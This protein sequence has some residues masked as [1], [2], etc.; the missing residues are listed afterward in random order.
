MSPNL[1]TSTR[2][3]QNF[4]IVPVQIQLLGKFEAKVNG[5]PLD[6][7]GKVVAFLAIRCGEIVERREIIEA[8]YPEADLTTALNRLRVALTKLRKHL[9]SALRES[10]QELYLDAEFVQTDLRHVQELI[11]SYRDHVTPEDEIQALKEILP[12]VEAEFLTGWNDAWVET[13]RSRWKRALSEPLQ[14]LVQL[15]WDARLVELT[16]DAARAALQLDSVQEGLWLTY[17]R[18]AA[19]QGKGPEAVAEWRRL[20]S[21]AHR[22]TL[23]AARDLARSL[24]LG[25]EATGREDLSLTPAERNFA[26]QVLERIL[27][28]NPTLAQEVL[29]APEILPLVG[30]HPRMTL[31]LLDR[32][33]ATEGTKEEVWVR[34]LARGIGLKAWLNDAQGVLEAAPK[35]LERTEEPL[36]KRAVWNAVSSAKAVQR[37]W[38]GAMEAIDRAIEIACAMPDPI[39]RISGIGNR[40]S[41]LWLQGHFETAL[42][43]YDAILADLSQMNSERAALEATVAKGNRAYIPTMQGDFATGLAW[44]EEA[45]RER[46]TNG[47]RIPLGLMGPCLA[48]LRLWASEP[49]GALDLMRDGLLE[50]FA[51]ESS[52][53]QQ[54]SIEYAGGGLIA[55]GEQNLARQILDWADDWRRQTGHLRAPAEEMLV[56]RLIEGVRAPDKPL[57]NLAPK[58]VAH[59]ALQRLRSALSSQKY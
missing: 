22:E 51:S 46:I 53:F 42:D 58:A 27:L 15:A 6:A 35:I 1:T 47:L 7:Y 11:A 56:S 43:E 5:V 8:L 33:V 12:W 40:A 23:P 57:G 9:G 18:A 3:R 45:Y 36:I 59:M 32:A 24:Q 19:T 34:C 49:K 2:N 28:T 31:S 50:A 41:Y 26:G 37:D 54:I 38:P 52:R 55:V 20:V 25:S 10:G 30:R 29:S 48:M 17:F 14:Q 13:E 21:P 4:S 39:E 44:M 16:Q